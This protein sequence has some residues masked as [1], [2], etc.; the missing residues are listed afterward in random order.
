MTTA[1]LQIPQLFVA[2]LVETPALDAALPDAQKLKSVQYTNLTAVTR[3]DAPTIRVRGR[4]LSR[5]NAGGRKGCV[6]RTLTVYVELI[7]RRDHALIAQDALL[8]K[9]V[10]RLNPELGSFTGYG[11]GV[12][13]ELAGVDVDA[14]SAD[15]EAILTRLEYAVNFFTAENSLTILT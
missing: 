13:P 4:R 11:S 2:R 6:S 1:L 14:E 8:E 5:G 7:L 10:D 15:Q 3:D 9:I 12:M